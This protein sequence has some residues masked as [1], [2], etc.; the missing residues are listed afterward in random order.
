[1]PRKWGT[2]H[3]AQKGDNPSLASFCY[4]CGSKHEFRTSFR[5]EFVDGL[6]LSLGQG[7]AA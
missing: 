1:M 4:Y 2:I 6:P 3:A 7:D 5:V